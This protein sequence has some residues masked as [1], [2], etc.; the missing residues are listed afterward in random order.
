[1][2]YFDIFN[3]K[4]KML[5]V[6]KNQRNKKNELSLRVH[7]S[8]WQG[9]GKFTNPWNSSE[10]NTYLNTKRGVRF[11]HVDTQIALILF[12]SNVGQW[13]GISS[14][15]CPFLK[16]LADYNLELQ[17]LK[18]LVTMASLQGRTEFGN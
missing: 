12:C 6:S 10:F 5:I 4:K 18:C 7:T 1:M 14:Y 9:W 11:F 13:R 3:E 17:M 15:K 2:A 16:K 8:N